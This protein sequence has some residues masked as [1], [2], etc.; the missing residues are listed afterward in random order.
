MNFIG[1]FWGVRVSE[2]EVE[3]SE[4]IRKD[5]DRY[6]VLS[7][8]SEVVSMG[9]CDIVSETASGVNDKIVNAAVEVE[10]I[11]EGRNCWVACSVHHDDTVFL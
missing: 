11:V 8:H 10:N 6:F 5:K 7:E 4:N 2:V 1:M 3:V 9:N